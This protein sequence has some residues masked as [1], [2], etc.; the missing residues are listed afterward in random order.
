MTAPAVDVLLPT[1]DRTTAL[2]A[3]L[4]GLLGQSSPLRLVLSDQS[5]QPTYDDG[6]V[7]GVLR[8]LRHTGVEVETH[9]RPRRQGI[10]EQVDFLLSRAAAPY[11]L[12]L[13]DDVVLE[14]G[15]LDRMVDALRELRCGFVGM[16]VTGLTLVDDDRPHE[17][18]AFELWDGEVRPERVR[19][20]TPAWERWRL[21]NAANPLHLARGLA[22]PARG[23][24][25]YKV[26]WVGGCTLYDVARLR[27][28][29]GFS[30]WPELGPY[31]Y[32]EDVAVQLLLME[33]YG[34]AGLL[35]TGAHHLQVPTT[36]PRREVDAYAVVVEAADRERDQVGVGHAQRA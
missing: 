32:G 2:A 29:G 1:V 27:E 15:A 3:T 6:A 34:G 7:A 16:A 18:E 20:G 14:R 28:V 19:S 5:E 12:V 22:V 35:P 17:R 8:V 10:A 31:G 30:F 21:H 25:A 23:W 24:V 26:A 36:L 11:A 33:R 4:T 13:G 9:H